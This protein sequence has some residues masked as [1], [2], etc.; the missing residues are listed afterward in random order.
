MRGKR[1]RRLVE[2]VTVSVTWFKRSCGIDIFCILRLTPPIGAIFATNL[3]STISVESEL[4]LSEI[5][6]KAEEKRGKKF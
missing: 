2:V 4:I 1:Q 5:V 6:K 3:D